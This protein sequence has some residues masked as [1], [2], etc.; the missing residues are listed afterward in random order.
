MKFGLRYLNTG[1]NVKSDK[2]ISMAQAAEEAGFES[3][4]TVDHVVVPKGYKST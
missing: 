3:I 4:W 2:A 1:R